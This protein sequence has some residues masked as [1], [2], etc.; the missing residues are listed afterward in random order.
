IE[1]I[2]IDDA[3]NSKVMDY[4]LVKLVHPL[5]IVHHKKTTAKKTA[6]ENGSFSER[7]L[8]EMEK[9]SVKKIIVEDGTLAIYN[10]AKNTVNKINH[11]SVE[12]N[13]LL[14]DSATRTDVNRFLFAKD[15]TIS[16]RDY[17]KPTKDGLYN[18]NIGSALINAPED[19]MKLSN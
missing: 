3:V 18:L 7:F 13:S 8:K 15:A 11:L 2:N 19:V 10:D 9:L 14:I 16:L 1:G 12:M 4:K 17:T 6:A 5:L